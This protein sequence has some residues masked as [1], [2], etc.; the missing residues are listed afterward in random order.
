M[1][2]YGK[3]DPA[4]APVCRRDDLYQLLKQLD[5][6]KAH[7]MGCSMGGEIVI[8][9]T[10][11]HPD[12]VSKLVAVSATPSGFEL[13]GEPPP[14]LLEMMDA[15]Q[16]GDVERTSELQIRIWVDGMYRQPE[17]VDPTVRERAA[18][19]NIIPV[20]NKTWFMESQPLNPLKPPAVE[21]LGD[22]QVPTLLVVGALDHPEILRAADVMEKTISGAQQVVIP[23]AAHVPNMEAPMLFN[24]AVIDFL[25]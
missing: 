21:R 24:Q 23:E 19:M 10:L 14:H 18:A 12:M 9:F 3:S 16:K 15:A 4:N 17:Q 11:E 8:D 25:K 22:I 1:R 13:L 6:N 2:G 5:V 7:F 20:K